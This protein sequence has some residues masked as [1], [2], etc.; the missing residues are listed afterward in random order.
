MPTEQAIDRCIEHWIDDIVESIDCHWCERRGMLADDCCWCG[1]TGSISL[2]HIDFYWLEC[3]FLKAN[4]LNDRPS[5]MQCGLYWLWNHETCEQ[6]YWLVT[7]T[8]A[9]RL[10]P[11][12]VYA[13]AAAMNR[14][15][16][17]NRWRVLKEFVQ[18]LFCLGGKHGSRKR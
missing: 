13:V 14:R 8:Q 10:H 11:E 4:L 12:R 15:E 3:E 17:D 9:F 7:E 2:D 1:G 5:W 6:V 18:F 16:R